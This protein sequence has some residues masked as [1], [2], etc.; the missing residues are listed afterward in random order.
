VDLKANQLL[1]MVEVLILKVGKFI[2]EKL[3]WKLRPKKEVI[4][5]KKAIQQGG[6]SF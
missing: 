3:S 1:A 4:R 2:I 6:G 5:F